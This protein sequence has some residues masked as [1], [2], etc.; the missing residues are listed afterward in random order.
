MADFPQVGDADGLK[1][2]LLLGLP[3]GEGDG[4]P[5]GTIDGAAVLFPLLELLAKSISKSSAIGSVLRRSERA[6]DR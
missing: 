4:T 5:L 2:G 3:E 1:L 6:L